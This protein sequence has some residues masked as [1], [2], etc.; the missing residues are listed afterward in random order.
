MR[1]MALRALQAHLESSF[2]APAATGL[3]AVL[4]LRIDAEALTFRV[5]HGA[6]EFDLPESVQPDATFMFEDVDTAWSLLS[7]QAD[8]FEA[9]MTGRFRSDGYLMWAFALMAIFQS[10][11]LPV[12]PVE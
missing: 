1:A 9:F 8:A 11:S 12:N 2:H 4:R 10:R 3:D 7:G 5:R 6:L